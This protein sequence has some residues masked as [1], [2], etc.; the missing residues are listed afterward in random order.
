MRFF[1][2]CHLGVTVFIMS[3]LLRM[4][5]F[6]FSLRIRFA[7]IRDEISCICSSRFS[8]FVSMTE[9]RGKTDARHDARRNENCWEIVS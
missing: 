8:L 6:T 4:S 9:I 2:P 1:Q 3:K 5:Y 7:L